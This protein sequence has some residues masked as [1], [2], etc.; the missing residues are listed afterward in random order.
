VTKTWDDEIYIRERDDMMTS[1]DRPRDR[2]DYRRAAAEFN[3]GT[4][5]I[6][7]TTIDQK[8]KNDPVI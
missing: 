5:N 2:V 1:F 6:I 3:F 7:I 4:V 8:G